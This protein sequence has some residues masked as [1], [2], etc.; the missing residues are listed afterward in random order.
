[1]RATP[2]ASGLGNKNYK[3]AEETLRL[4]ARGHTL[5][6]VADIRGRQLGSV[7][8]LVADMVETGQLD[9]QAHW[10][11]ADKVEGIEA[12]CATVGGERLRP[13]KD[14]LPPE[15]TFDEIRLVLA[16]QRAQ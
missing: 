2:S 3:P 11:G 12:A 10:V 7:V 9:F 8:A 6:E 16:K 15:I 14:A 5:Q 13:I 1:A 4:L